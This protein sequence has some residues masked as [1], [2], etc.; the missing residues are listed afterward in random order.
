MTSKWDSFNKPDW[1]CVTRALKIMEDK[2][3]EDESL[4]E[5]A[6]AI[7]VLDENLLNRLNMWFEHNE[8][9]IR[10]VYFRSKTDG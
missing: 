7:S 1:N 3:A 10:V 5:I 9:P 6:L 8:I 2:L 4:K